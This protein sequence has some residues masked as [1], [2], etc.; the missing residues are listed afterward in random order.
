M[1]TVSIATL[2][3]HRACHLDGR[4]ADLEAHLE[5]TVPPDEEVPFAVW[6]EVTPHTRD[7]IWA[8]RAV[9]GGREIAVEVA[10]RSAER[11]ADMAKLPPDHAA[12]TCI[13][14]TRGFMAGDVDRATLDAAANAVRGLTDIAWAAARAAM[15]SVEWSAT[16]ASWAVATAWDDPHARADV[17][18]LTSL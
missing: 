2:R 1:K 16:W 10:V 13:A 18:E 15:V 3:A 7:L 6:A 11:A 9:D 5:R 17:L 8:L 12:R 14:T 4:I